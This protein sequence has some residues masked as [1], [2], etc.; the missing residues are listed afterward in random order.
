MGT[1][2]IARGYTHKQKVA[3]TTWVINHG[4]LLGNDAV[5][6]FVTIGGELVKIIPKSVAHSGNTFT[7]TFSTAYTGEAYVI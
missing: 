3:S 4:D 5:E 7:V 1:T 2:V 6:V